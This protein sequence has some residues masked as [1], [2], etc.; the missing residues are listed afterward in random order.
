[1][2]SSKLLLYKRLLST[3]LSQI[4]II[5]IFSWVKTNPYHRHLHQK[6]VLSLHFFF[7]SGFLSRTLTTY[8]TAGER[9][10][11]SFILLYHFHPL[12]NI[13]TF[14]CNFAREMTITYFNRNAC[15]YQTAT[16]WDL[17]PYRI[18]IWLIDDVILIFV[19]LLVDLILGLVTAIW[20]EK[21]VDSN[22]HQLSSLMYLIFFFSFFLM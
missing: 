20:H 11:P 9:R 3:L 1:M 14:I 7:L 12:T 17:P 19:C 21:P 13:Q 2:T 8:R 15:I 4:V 6:K 18:T 5:M 10:G 16:R 22:S